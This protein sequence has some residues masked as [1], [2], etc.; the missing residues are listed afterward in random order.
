MQ[1]LGS[2]MIEPSLFY[3]PTNIA[4]VTT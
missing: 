1:R 4:C 3:K 2:T